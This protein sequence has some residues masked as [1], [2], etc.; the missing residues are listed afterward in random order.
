MNGLRD[1]DIL[2]NARLTQNNLSTLLSQD[3]N[4]NYKGDLVNQIEHVQEILDQINKQ[5][6]GESNVYGDNT[7]AALDDLKKYFDEAR[8]SY[9]QAVEY[10]KQLHQDYLDMLDQAKEKLDAQKENYE[11]ITNL[12]EHDKRLVE[13]TYGEKAYAILD[14]YYKLQKQNNKDELQVL[15]NQEKYY[16]TRMDNAQAEMLAAKAALRDENLTADEYEKRNSKYLETV[17]KFE[18]TK[19][20]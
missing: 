3:E 5:K 10:Q 7:K 19:E 9:E 12:L 18:K 11:Q 4:G 16:K 13:L 8:N 20:H 1:E 2:G 15:A 17:E 6:N 14:K